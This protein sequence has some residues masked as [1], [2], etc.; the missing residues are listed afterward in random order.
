MAEAVDVAVR[1]LVGLFLNCVS[2][3][4]ALNRRNFPGVLI[5]RNNQSRVRRDPFFES[6][7]PLLKNDLI[8]DTW[9]RGI[10]APELDKSLL[11]ILDDGSEYRRRLDSRSLRLI[12]SSALKETPV[13]KS[14][15]IIVPVFI[16]LFLR[17]C[18]FLQ[19]ATL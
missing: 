9:V 3:N 11:N 15:T 5:D 1:Q 17:F 6:F 16:A 10:E 8:T 13:N 2:T 7:I 4:I 19:V 18:L 14:A 12:S